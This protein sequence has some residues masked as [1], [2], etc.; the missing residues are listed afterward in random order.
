VETALPDDINSALLLLRVVLGLT[1]A[2]HGY[3]KFFQGGRI[4]GTAGW[5]DSM[6]MRPGR[7][8]A[9]LA[10][11]TEVGTGLLLVAG[12]L[13]SFA[14]AGLVGLMV[15]AGWTVHRHNG[16][17]IIKEGWEYVF[18]LA[19]VAIALAT[20]GPGDWS[21]DGALDIDRDLDG[22]TGMA[23]SAGLGLA[24]GVGLLAVFYR[25][26]PETD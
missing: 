16:F 24:A 17:F 18:M 19:I 9:L 20:F 14:A 2:A 5:F 10:A 25:P 23:I 11:T 15:V 3:G 12:L 22:W 21:L 26:P 8:H 4:S 13:T 1:I 7:V 6:G